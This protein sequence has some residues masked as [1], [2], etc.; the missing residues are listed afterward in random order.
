MPEVAGR[1]CI[2]DLS[3]NFLFR[4]PSL[5]AIGPIREANDLL[6]WLG[7]HAIHFVSREPSV[8]TAVLRAGSQWTDLNLWAAEIPVPSVVALAAK[9][10]LVP[11]A[12]VW[13]HLKGHPL[14]NCLMHPKL[15]HGAFLVNPTWQR[16]I[17]TALDAVLSRRCK[18]N[19]Y[20]E[21]AGA[22]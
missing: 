20:L 5:A 14:V 9:D 7:M 4:R 17:L 19:G 18:G 6:R 13:Q 10:T 2:Q 1:L 22:Y 12:R 3:H 8:S 11:T 21:P 15:S 16:E